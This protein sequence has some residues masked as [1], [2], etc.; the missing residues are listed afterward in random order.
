MRL[1]IT[2]LMI[3]S[4]WVLL[5]PTN[6]Y[7]R[8]FA[9]YKEAGDDHLRS[10]RSALAIGEY[11][12][13]LELDP[14]STAVYFDL[15]IAYYKEQDLKETVSSLEKITQLDPNDTEA[16]YNLGCL[17]LYGKNF[18]S[19]CEYFKKAQAWGTLEFVVKLKTLDPQTQDTILLS[20]AA[21]SLL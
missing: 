10:D 4:A 8:T 7:C 13:A 17:K 15:A 20:L 21:R 1:K 18:G 6:A 19:A 16:Y 2:G 9:E 14:D 11:K 12:K 3:V 5:S